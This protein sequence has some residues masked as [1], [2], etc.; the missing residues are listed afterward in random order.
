MPYVGL[1]SLHPF[2]LKTPVF[3]R[4]SGPVFLCI[5]LNCQIFGYNKFKKW[6][7]RKLYFKNTI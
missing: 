6:A 7:G 5:Y 3:M 2:P 4:V 1:T